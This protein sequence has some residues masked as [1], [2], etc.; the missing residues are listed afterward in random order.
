MAVSG[1]MRPMPALPTPPLMPKEVADIVDVIGN[2]TRTEILNL[3]ATRV[4]TANEL[5]AETGVD[6]TT[7]RRHL[8]TLEDHGLVAGTPPPAERTPGGRGR[9]ISWS[10]DH[11]QVAAQG[12]QW[13]AY[14]TGQTA[15]APSVEP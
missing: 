11:A 12:Q 8:E 9:K 15:A 4:M 3:I 5:A 13:I 2:R 10:T 14:A 1:R 7:I 6:V